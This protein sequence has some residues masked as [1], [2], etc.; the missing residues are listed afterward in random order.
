MSDVC[1][2]MVS[3]R[4]RYARETLCGLSRRGRGRETFVNHDT[5]DHSLY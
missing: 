2:G 1:L 4:A 3:I 5:V